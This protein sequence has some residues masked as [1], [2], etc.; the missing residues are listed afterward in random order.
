MLASAPEPFDPMEK[1]FHDLRRERMQQ[2]ARLHGP[3]WKLVHAYGLR[4]GLLAMSHVWQAVH[5]GHEFVIA[6]KGAP[7][8]IADLCHFS[9][10]DLDAVKQTVDAMASEGMRVLG[11]A[12]ASSKGPAWPDS[13]HDFEFEF[14]GLVGLTDPLRPGVPDAVGQCRSAGI[15][16]IMITGDY[17][18]TAKAIARQAGLDAEDLVTGEM[19]EQLS[20][21][22][23]TGRVRTATVFARVL[24]EQKLR[25]SLI[26]VNRSFSASLATTL[27]RPNALLTARRRCAVEPD[28]AVAVGPRT[29]PVRALHL[30][31]LAVTLG[32]GLV[33]LVLL[34]VLKPLWRKRLARE[35]PSASPVS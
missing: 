11:V 31:D 9:A 19:L 23:L 18:A 4:P 32:A 28:A 8:A 30:G 34:E 24:P 16:V 17:P 27:R 12:R 15:K 14:L 2:T 29:V 3:D 21:A 35:T 1:A 25:I 22:Q 20:D 33:V 10:A 6:A 13:Q 26:F 5:G 7:E